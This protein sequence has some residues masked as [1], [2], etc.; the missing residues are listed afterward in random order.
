MAKKMTATELAERTDNQKA[1]G[2]WLRS[3]GSPRLDQMRPFR[4][5]RSVSSIA[6]VPKEQL[7]RITVASGDMAIR[8]QIVQE[9]EVENVLPF[10]AARV[11]LRDRCCSGVLRPRGS[12]LAGSSP[13][14]W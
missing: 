2:C 12:E 3:I 14:L 1:M 5:Q 10:R 11:E 7:R 9:T 13:S 8:Y 6:T 4:T